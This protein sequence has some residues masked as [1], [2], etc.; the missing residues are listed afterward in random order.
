[1]FQK[2]SL[3]TDNRVHFMKKSSFDI[4]GAKLVSVD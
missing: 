4:F 1:M 2:L 3:N